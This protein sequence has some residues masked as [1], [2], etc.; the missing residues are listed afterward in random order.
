ML[1][2]RRKKVKIFKMLMK[3]KIDL[4]YFVIIELHA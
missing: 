4:K 3:V 1:M 2:K